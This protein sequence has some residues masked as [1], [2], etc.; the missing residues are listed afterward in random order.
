MA[1]DIDVDDDDDDDDD[2]A[3]MSVCQPASDPK[4]SAQRSQDSLL[5]VFLHFWIGI[6]PSCQRPFGVDPHARREL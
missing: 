2:G 4:Q 1:T 5:Q 6:L 3:L